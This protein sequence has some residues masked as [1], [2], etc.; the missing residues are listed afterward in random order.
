MKKKKTA[1]KKKDAVTSFW[2]NFQKPKSRPSPHPKRK[3]A[4][5]KP[6]K[7]TTKKEKQNDDNDQPG[8]KDPLTGQPS[9]NWPRETPREPESV[10]P[11]TGKPPVPHEPVD[12]KTLSG[13]TK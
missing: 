6:P 10:D 2:N 7:M 4:K 9:K 13:E 12:P 11:L 1:K 8:T 3:T 5:R